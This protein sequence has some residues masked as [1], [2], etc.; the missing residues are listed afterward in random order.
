MKHG[1]REFGPWRF[2]MQAFGECLPY[3]DNRVSLHAAKLDRFG[4]PQLQFN[5]T[6]RD[7]ELS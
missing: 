3:E 5:V 6:F 2:G 7:N 4:I 1:M